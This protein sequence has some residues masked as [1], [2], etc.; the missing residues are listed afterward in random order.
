MMHAVFL[1]LQ[2]ELKSRGVP[3]EMLHGPSRVQ[4]QPGSIR[5]VFERDRQSG[6]QV[7]GPR[8]EHRNPHAINV[9]AIGFVIRVFAQST[10]AGACNYDHE[11]V[12]DNVVDCIV[13][14]MRVV[15]AKARTMMR[16]TSCKM[17]SKTDLAAL[18][19]ESWPGA[20]YEL[21]GQIDRGVFDLPYRR[22]AAPEVAWSSI[23]HENTTN[24]SGPTASN[25]LP[26]ST[27]RVDE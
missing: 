3:F 24:V 4:L 5:I 6:D 10:K 19:I 17:L 21:C 9:R 26:N 23:A 11:D 22:D 13:S 25:G 16:W 1:E 12:V 2:A 18:D 14:A 15:T 7:L 8:S 27:S 20:A